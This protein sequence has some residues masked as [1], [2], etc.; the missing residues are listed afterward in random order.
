MLLIYP[1]SRHGM[2]WED[3]PSVLAQLIPPKWSQITTPVSQ[4][5]SAS[6]TCRMW[7]MQSRWVEYCFCILHGYVCRP[8]FYVYWLY[9]YVLYIECMLISSKSSIVFICYRTIKLTYLLTYKYCV[10]GCGCGCMRVQ[11]LPSCAC[12]HAHDGNCRHCFFIISC[13][14]FFMLFLS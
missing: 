14:T 13:L 8:L 6:S 2:I 5:A 7:T 1:T 12:M 11:Q 3:L 9:F 4:E 10:C